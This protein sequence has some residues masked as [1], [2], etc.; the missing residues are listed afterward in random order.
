M[1]GN[2]RNSTP[3]THHSFFICFLIVAC[4]ELKS[5]GRSA[6]NRIEVAILSAR[7]TWMQQP[8]SGLGAGKTSGFVAGA[9]TFGHCSLMNIFFKNLPLKHQ[10]IFENRTANADCREWRKQPPCQP[11]YVCSLHTPC[12]SARML[13][14]TPPM[15][16]HHLSNPGKTDWRKGT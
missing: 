6:W 5:V 16:C 3:I 8:T 15:A 14:P 1:F 9:W 7:S 11:T 12:D 4:L 2:R 13:R 10:A